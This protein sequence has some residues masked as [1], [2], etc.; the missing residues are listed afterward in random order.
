MRSISMDFVVADDYAVLLLPAALHRHE[1][2][3]S[4]L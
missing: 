1:L 4:L 3:K 2:V